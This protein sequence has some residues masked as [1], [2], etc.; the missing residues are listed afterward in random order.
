MRGADERA[1]PNTERLREFTEAALPRIEQQLYA[2]VP[3]YP[4]VEALTLSFSLQRMREWLGRIIR[5]CGSL[6]AKES[7]DALATRL[8]AE[9]K[10]DDAAVR[11]QLWEGGKAGGRRVARSDDRACALARRRFALDSQAVRGRS[12][13]ADRRPLRKESPR[14]RFKA[15]GTHVYPDA[16]FTLRLNYGTVQ[17]W[18]ENGTPVEPFTHL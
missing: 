7:P 11:K 3:I 18:A 15:Y 1:K 16:T 2:P 8:V 9:T 12:R 13:G 14:R 10:L 4:E 5:W 6:F 17:G